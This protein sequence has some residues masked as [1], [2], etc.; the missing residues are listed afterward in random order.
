[1]T[2]Y[3]NRLIHA[4]SPYLLQHA[5]NPVDWY[6]WGNEALAKAKSENKPI[7]LS[8]GY[9]TC[10]WCHVMAHES[11]EDE[12]VAELLNRHFVSIKVDREERPDLD[13]VY[14][15]VTQ[16]M[17]GSGGWPMTVVLTPDK[18][19]FFAGTYFPKSTRWGKP[20]MMELL[21]AI[22]E[23]WMNRQEDVLKTA[24][25][26]T[27]LM[28]ETSTLPPGYRLTEDTLTRAENELSSRFDA[29]H[30]GFG[31]APKFPTPHQLTFL[32]R[33]YRHSG[34]T[35]LLK[36][37]ETTLQQ[38]RNGG[39]FDHI[40]FGFHR[41]ATDANWLVPHFEKMLYDQALITM[42]YLEAWQVTGNA[43]YRETVQHIAMYVMDNLCAPEGGFFTA[44][45][46]DSEG[47]EGKFY[48]WRLAEVQQ[49]L[50]E[51]AAALFAKVY[52]LTEEGN[53]HNE[54][55]GEKEG[56]NIPH[57]KHSPTAFA[58]E[59]NL[60][61]SVLLAQIEESRQKLLAVRS[62]RVHPFKDDK[63]LTDWNGLMIAALAKAGSVLNE[64]IYTR[65]AKRAADFILKTLRDSNGRLLK[66]FRH[67]KAQGEGLLDDYA[68]FIW[69]LIALYE[70][71]FDANYLEAAMALSDQMLSRFQDSK[72][73]GLF[74]SAIDGE[75]PL[76]KY[77]EI[78]DGALPS[79]N[80]VAISN[81]LRLNGLTGS[82]RYGE[83]AERIMIAFSTLVSRNPSANTHFL[84]ALS[85]AL[86]PHYEVVVVGNP[87]APDTKRMLGTLQKQFLPETTLIFKPDGPN[88]GIGRLT[89]FTTAMTPINRQATAYVCRNFA[90]NL[91][92][93]DIDEMM[94]N[95]NAKR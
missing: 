25:K 29:A 91:P 81:L 84:T 50:G 69:G 14:M 95:L 60:S 87:N 89:P 85:F 94:N 73:G 38:M 31:T 10:H 68:Y 65:T 58:Q 48:V 93:T 61:E 51:E 20:G 12:A 4:T 44:E 33:Q 64:P 35:G 16:Q 6:P 55:S 77:R 92:T 59:M 80:S 11:F 52:G 86:H 32:L 1:M 74:I 72:K 83:A 5:E 17:T 7:F 67:G 56:V 19:P 54:A 21:P 9:S 49:V 22:H 27:D 75:E 79:G 88:E 63:I 24:N 36:M 42:A 30:G 70:S 46:A 76:F 13:A 8:I 82:T 15:A 3:Q 57:L 53:F 26:I 34:V 78:H 23:A 28:A 37:V 39:I 45:D 43:L 66:S 40:G 47:V 62:R 2:T 71:L 90:C 41:Y 18:K